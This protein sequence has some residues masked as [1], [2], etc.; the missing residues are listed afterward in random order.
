SSAGW[1]WRPSGAQASPPPSRH[2]GTGLQT[3]QTLA[4][5]KSVR[6]TRHRLGSEAP[7]AA[8]RLEGVA[9]VELD[10]RIGLVHPQL[11]AASVGSPQTDPGTTLLVAGEIGEGEVNVQRADSPPGPEFES[12][13]GN[14]LRPHGQL[15]VN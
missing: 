3:H 11:R 1:L 13:T 2:S 14:V 4:G 6:R 8:V 12:R 9:R 7:A 10:I 5:L 15:S